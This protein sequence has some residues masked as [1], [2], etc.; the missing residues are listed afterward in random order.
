MKGGQTDRQ[1]NL[2]LPVRT[3]RMHTE[4]GTYWKGYKNLSDLHNMINNNHTHTHTHTHTLPHMTTDLFSSPHVSAILAI[5]RE[6][7]WGFQIN[8]QKCLLLLSTVL[9]LLQNITFIRFIHSIIHSFIHSIAPCQHNSCS[10]HLISS[11]HTFG[12]Q[13]CWRPHGY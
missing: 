4:Q 7:L 3:P 6:I 2:I 5:I 1:T 8:L 11:A 12:S 9:K 13:E 10:K